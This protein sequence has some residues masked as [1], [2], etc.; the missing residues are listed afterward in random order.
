[1]GE[2]KSELKRTNHGNK[3]KYEHVRNKWTIQQLKRMNTSTNKQ[4]G[5]ITAHTRASLNMI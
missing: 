1:M 4:T 5:R 2:A 3:W